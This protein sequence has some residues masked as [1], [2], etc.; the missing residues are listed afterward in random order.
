MLAFPLQGVYNRNTV[1]EIALYAR[2]YLANGTITATVT[3]N[4]TYKIA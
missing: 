1:G 4:I 3:I 2:K